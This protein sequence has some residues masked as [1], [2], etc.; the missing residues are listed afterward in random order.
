ME[1]DEEYFSGTS[2]YGEE[3]LI[4]E[5]GGGEVFEFEFADGFEGLD[6]DPFEGFC[7]IESRLWIPGNEQVSGGGDDAS[8]EGCEAGFDGK[9]E[10]LLIIEVDGAGGWCDGETVGGVKEDFGGA[11]GSGA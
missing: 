11:G 2:E 6:I 4:E 3:L 10:F 8:V 7:V 1:V 5:L 9:F